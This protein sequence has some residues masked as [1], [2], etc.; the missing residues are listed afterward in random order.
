[1]S[2]LQKHFFFYSIIS[3]CRFSILSHF[4][5]CTQLS[6][7]TYAI[8]WS[9]YTIDIQKMIECMQEV[10]NNHACLLNINIMMHPN[11][12]KSILTTEAI[13]PVIRVPVERFFRVLTKH[14]YKHDPSSKVFCV[15][16]QHTKIYLQVGCLCTSVW[17]KIYFF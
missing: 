4:P 6:T 13:S 16:L 11:M 1:M 15:N 5:I 12:Y 2:I 3:F 9:R 17:Q 10:E 14:P 7:I 8:L